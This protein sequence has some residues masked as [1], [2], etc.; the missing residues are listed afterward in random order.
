MHF[1]SIIRS[2]TVKFFEKTFFKMYSGMK[3]RGSRDNRDH[4]HRN[5]TVTPS[6]QESCESPYAFNRWGHLSSQVDTKILSEFATQEGRRPYVGELP[7]LPTKQ[8]TTKKNRKL[9][10]DY[11]LEVASNLTSPHA[12]KLDKPEGHYFC[13][14]DDATTRHRQF[15]NGIKWIW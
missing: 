6:S 4:S 13:S 5:S 1:I 8:N 15:Y 9:F 7:G 10:K 3:A 11:A 2:Y 14:V 12:P